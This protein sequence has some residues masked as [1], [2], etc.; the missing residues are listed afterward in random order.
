MRFR[1]PFLSLLFLSMTLADFVP[2]NCNYIVPFPGNDTFP[3]LVAVGPRLIFGGEP[4]QAELQAKLAEL[5]TLQNQLDNL[6]S[7][8]DLVL[9]QEVTA[10]Q[11]KELEG[12]FESLRE[13]WNIVNADGDT[14]QALQATVI[15]L[16][17][18]LENAN[19]GKPEETIKQLQITIESLNSQLKIDYSRERVRELEGIVADLN[20]Q[21]EKAGPTV[22]QI[23]QFQA[24]IDQLTKH[25]EIAKGNPSSAEQIQSLESQISELREE[26]AG[27][28]M[29]SQIL[30]QIAEL[31]RTINSLREQFA[32]VDTAP[33]IELE[34][35]IERL[36]AKLDA[37]S[38]ILIPRL[39]NDIATTSGLISDVQSTISTLNIQVSSSNPKMVIS[40]QDDSVSIRLQNPLVTDFAQLLFKR[41]LKFMLIPD[42]VAVPTSSTSFNALWTANAAR[43]ACRKEVLINTTIASFANDATVTGSDTCQPTF[44]LKST[45]E[46]IRNPTIGCALTQST[47]GSGDASTVA[48][49]GKI[50]AMWQDFYPADAKRKRPQAN[51]PASVMY[52]PMSVSFKQSVKQ[53]ATQVMNGTDPYVADS[54]AITDVL[55]TKL[56]GQLKLQFSYKIG[57]YYPYLLLPSESA[58]VLAGNFGIAKNPLLS[59]TVKSF[60]GATVGLGT[61]TSTCVRPND[62]G[63]PANVAITK[64]IGNNPGDLVIPANRECT[65]SQTVE[66]TW[67]Y[68][69]TNTA[70]SPQCDVAGDY[71]FNWATC[72]YTSTHQGTN[73]GCILPSLSSSVG[74]VGEVKIP[75]SIDLCK[76][77]TTDYS[78]T[79]SSVLAPAAAVYDVG[80][81]VTF[82]TT[83][84][85]GKQITTGVIQDFTIED[86]RNGAPFYTWSLYQHGAVTSASGTLR[87][88]IGWTSSVVLDPAKLVATVNIGYTPAIGGTSKSADFLI[89]LNDRSVSSLTLRNTLRVRFYFDSQDSTTV[90]R[91]LMY[92]DT[93]ITTVQGASDVSQVAST[94][95]KIPVDLRAPETMTTTSSTGLS[96]AAVASI[97]AIGTALVVAA[98]GVGALVYRRRA[99]V[100]ISSTT[101]DWI[102]KSDAATYNL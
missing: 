58:S 25:L 90:T 69:D 38:S 12:T 32:A 8:L 48:Y 31:E 40:S 82:A 88:N 84:T 34:A 45:W 37:G 76:A 56:A 53:N 67:A 60:S 18:Q 23:A 35:E 99:N 3:P 55:Y 24:I 93:T 10:E 19:L 95:I 89:A 65:Y 62:G 21:I 27:V 86:V 47:F 57:A 98:A 102:S 92:R 70:D 66:Y 20:V 59:G 78:L 97:A 9:K 73:A 2:S 52:Y 61:F 26:L 42:S 11:V 64:Q 14:I 49:K 46:A 16:Q 13:Q 51:R 44:E 15:D 74:I 63:P 5:S 71:T 79:T 72:T 77:P 85:S 6:Q 22:V 4:P 7:Q 1:V 41:S 101:N 36:T 91:R 100:Q 54:F 83:I 33:V 28:K 50:V 30:E 94:R 81:R 96:T 75:G 43:T 39:E 68:S 17:S 29:D 80:S 87:S